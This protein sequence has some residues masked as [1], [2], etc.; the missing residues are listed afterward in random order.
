MPDRDVKIIRDQIYFQYAKLTAR[1]TLC[2][3]LSTAQLACAP[4]LQ[5]RSVYY[6]LS[7]ISTGNTRDQ[8]QEEK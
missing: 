1:A 3:R 4:E 7:R 2:L 6:Q 5:R 8:K